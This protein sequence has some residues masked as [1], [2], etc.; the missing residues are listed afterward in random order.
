MHDFTDTIIKIEA[1]CSEAI[2]AL[3]KVNELYDKANP[4]YVV[5]GNRVEIKLSDAKMDE[6]TIESLRAYTQAKDH[7]LAALEDIEEHRNLFKHILTT[8]S[9]P[10]FLNA[11]HQRDQPKDG[12]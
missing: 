5:E 10:A 12:E 9:D 4:P 1:E 6:W 8:D 3:K 7:L 11:P 2:H